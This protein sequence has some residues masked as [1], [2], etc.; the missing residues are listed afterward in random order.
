MENYKRADM[1]MKNVDSTNHSFGLW[2]LVKNYIMDN[3]NIILVHFMKK[4]VFNLLK[5]YFKSTRSTV[6]SLKLMD[7]RQN[8]FTP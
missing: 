8:S 1:M 5:K 2:T 3:F 7:I 4:K 6:K